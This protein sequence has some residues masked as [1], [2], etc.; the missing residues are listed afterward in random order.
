MDFSSYV[1]DTAFSLIIT[2]SPIYGANMARE[3][4]LL[5]TNAISSDL[6]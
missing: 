5:Q 2:F 3:K 1:N 6:I 4:A